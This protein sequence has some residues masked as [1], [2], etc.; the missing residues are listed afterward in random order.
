MQ[1]KATIPKNLRIVDIVETR[2][3]GS[4]TAGSV[5]EAGAGQTPAATDTVTVRYAGWTLQGKLFDAS[6]PGTASFPLNRVI[7]GWTEGLQLLKE[8]GSARFVIP[9]QL[10]YGERGAPPRIGPGA[11]LV[12]HVELL[13][14]R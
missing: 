12:F 7:P 11:T 13:K 9:P 1:K 10:A 8:G 14:V 5:P 4:T 6:Y 2:R 3:S